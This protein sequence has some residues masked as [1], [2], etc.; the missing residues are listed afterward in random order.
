M[1][2]FDPE[3]GRCK[4]AFVRHYPDAKLVARRN[5]SGL[6]A[7]MLAHEAKHTASNFRFDT[8]T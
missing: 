3:D 6:S 8:T 2:W 4:K 7:S 1:T 5:P